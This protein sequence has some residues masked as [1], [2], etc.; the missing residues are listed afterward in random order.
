MDTA[1]LLDERP[2]GERDV[3]E[4][5]LR[6]LRKAR[7]FIFAENQYLASPLMCAAIQRALER[8][9]GLEVIL[10]LNAGLDIPSYGRHQQTQLARL[11]GHPRVGAFARWHSMPD[12]PRTVVQLGYLHSK[13]TIIDDEWVA[14][15]TANLD[16]FRFHGAEEFGM[17]STRN[18]ETNMTLFDGIGGHPKTGV[19]EDLR[20]RLWAE[21][22]GVAARADWA[23]CMRVCPSR[24]GGGWRK[25]KSPHLTRAGRR[26]R[27]SCPTHAPKA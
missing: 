2:D 16:G 23:S 10:F 15:D 27:Q 9:P 6:A 26:R 8:A 12:G 7:R 19:A 14:L 25:T 22:L 17:P 20:R 13:T 11:I 21:H 3:F 1:G 5:Y 24:S 4:S 18:V